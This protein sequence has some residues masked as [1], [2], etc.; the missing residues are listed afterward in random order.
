MRPGAAAALLAVDGDG[1]AL[2]VALVADGDGDLLVGDEV[3]ELEFGGLVDDLRAALV[4]VAVADVF[5]FLDDDRAELFVAGEDGF[6][7]GDLVADLL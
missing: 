7:F 2:E 3:F 1:R 6:V 4:A 5:E